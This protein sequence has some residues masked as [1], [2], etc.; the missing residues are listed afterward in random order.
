[1]T[2]SATAGYISLI[3]WEKSDYLFML[4]MKPE[5]MLKRKY[6]LKF[7]PTLRDIN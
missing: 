6:S 5:I 2:L 4:R 3:L 7:T 1:M